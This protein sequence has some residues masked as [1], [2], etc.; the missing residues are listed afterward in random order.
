[1]E[2]PQIAR[3]NLHPLTY[4]LFPMRLTLLLLFLTLLL[5]LHAQGSPDAWPMP[6]GGREYRAVW[7]CTLGGM[8]WP[9]NAYA[10]TEQ[11][12]ERQRRE[13]CRRF[14]QLQAAG[15]NTILFQTRIRSTVA[16]PSRFEPWDGAF[17]GTPG[18]APPY[19]VL[20]FAIEEAHR[21]GMELH[22]YLVAFPIC[23]VAQA[24]QL[25][26]QALPVRRP[27]LCVRA[28]DKWLMDPGVPATADYLAD[29]CRE[30]VERYDVDGIHLDY[31]RYPEHSIPFNDDRT[32]ARYGGGQPRGAWRRANVS[33]VVQRIS[34]SV[35]AVRPWLRLSCAPVGKHADLPRQ[36]AGGWNAR[37]AVAQDAQRW[38]R[39]GWMD[40]LFPMMY[41]DGTQFYPFAFDWQ[42]QAA[43]RHIVPGLAAYFLS[44]LEGKWILP[45]IVR[46]MNV[47]RQAGMGQAFF[48]TAF[49]LD[50][51][52]GILDWT[53]DFY[54]QPALPPAMTWAD[55]IPPAAPVHTQRVEGDSLRLRWPAVADTTPVTYNVYRI[56]SSGLRLIAT[57]LRTNTYALPVTPST[58]QHSRHIVRAMDAYGN[59]SPLPPDP[60][61][62]VDDP[63]PQRSPRF[64]PYPSARR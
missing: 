6:E 26:S 36:S 54:R 45:Q 24:R 49:L 23:S 1:M 46:Q 48:R 20:A 61:P 10:Q 64:V 50:N 12:A 42:Q 16:Y 56:T 57:R 3:A 39:E 41:F 29:L 33:R 21:R 51:H 7:F 52:K 4:C 38:L 2:T 53:R 62:T 28:G 37:D 47:L 31:I 18:V 59:E 11:K 14:D 5:P 44:P 13:L 55:S 43:G 34:R 22:A 19:D 35:R 15:I 25:G 17:S 60:R 40:V 32:Y 63:H 58:Q 30:I 8:D 9:G 27:D